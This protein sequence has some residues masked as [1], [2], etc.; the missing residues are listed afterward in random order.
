MYRDELEAARQRIA[1]LEEQLRERDAEI[2][3]LRRARAARQ[4]PARPPWRRRFVALTV[5]AGLFGLLVLAPLLPA[6]EA[7]A[8]AGPEQ[9]AAGQP[10]TALGPAPAGMAGRAS[11]GR[12]GAPRATLTDPGVGIPAPGPRAASVERMPYSAAMPGALGGLGTLG[13]APALSQPD[14][15]LPQ[16]APDRA[17]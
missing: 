6:E 1:S 13:P 15:Q 9:L 17:R 10:G 16:T 4:D 11:A 3:E 2:A 5:I 7:K 14:S 12:L 8:P